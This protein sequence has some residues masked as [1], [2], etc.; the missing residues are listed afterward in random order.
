VFISDIHVDDFTLNNGQ[1]GSTDLVASWN[2]FN[3][4]VRME[5]ESILDDLR[6]MLIKGNYFISS[7]VLDFSVS[8]ERVPVKIIQPYVDN[9]FTGLEGTI[10]SEMKL[11]GLINSPLLNGTIE[12][13]RAALTL[14]YTKTRYSFSGVTTV[15]DNTIGLKGIELFDRFGNS[16]KISEGSISTDNFKDIAFD[17]QLAA[18]NLEVLDTKERDNSLFY[19]KAFATGSIRIKGN[20]Q[21]I[22]LDIVARTEKNTQFNIPLSSS[23]EVART[24]FISFVDHT[25]RA[26]KRSLDFRR[27]RTVVA[28]DESVVEPKF[29]IHMNLDVTPDAEAQLIFDAKIGDIMRARGSGNLRMNVANGQFDMMGTYTV[30]EGDYLFTLQNVVNKKFTIEK[31]GIITWNGDPMGA[32]LNLKAVYATKPSLYDLIGDENSRRS[33]PVECVLHITNILTNPNIRF[34]LAMPNAE[35][36]VRSFLNA[37]TNSEEEMTRQFLS[38]LVMNRFYPDPNQTTGNGTSSSGLETMGLATASEFLTSQL[39]YMISQWSNNFDVD[40]SYRPG[41]YE[42]GQNIGMGVTTNW[43]NIHMDYEVA[44]ENSDNVVGDFTFDIKL[45]KSGKLR[46]KAF[47]RANATYLSQNPNTQGIGLLFRE[48]FNHL[49]DLF[50]RKKA[51]VV[52][53]DEDDEI[54]ETEEVQPENQDKKPATA[55]IY[56]DEQVTDDK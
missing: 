5:A 47:N 42:T 19:G 1:L 13:R 9:V 33:V 36:E 49:R 32:L 35:Q 55:A 28:S 18:N 4:S 12:M 6:T 54:S 44:T 52:R 53:R 15:K 25:P 14:D 20:P 38:L 43:W 34:E 10:S 26:Q 37:A 50:K 22:Q 41:T 8:L 39:G 2:N 17:L 21:D 45:N 11:T 16:C 23:D 56:S 46:F 24:T 29:A 7:H 30:E 31:G 51:P 3:R 48:D 40:F 27:R